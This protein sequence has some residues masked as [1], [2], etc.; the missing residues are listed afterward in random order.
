MDKEA[1]DFDKLVETRL[2]ASLRPHC[3]RVLG[4]N[5]QGEGS[6]M[7]KVLCVILGGGQGTR[8]FP[9]TKERCKPAMPLLG[10]YRLIDVAISNCLN[11][12]FKHIYI[13]T[14][15]LSESLNKHINRT[16]QMDSFS[17]GFIEIIAA[18][19]SMED[20]NWFQGTA[21]A[22]R[23]CLKHFNDPAVEHVLVLSGD[24]LYKMNLRE[25]YQYH[26]DKKA[27]VTLACNYTNPEEISG[28]G[29]M[30]IDDE[31]RINRFI[32]K[33]KNLSEVKGMAAGTKDAP[34]FLSSMGIYL[35]KKA[36]LIELLTK[37][38]KVDFGKE[39]I[40]DAIK[41]KSAFAF[42]FNG[43]WRDIGTIKNFYNENLS[44]TSSLPPLDLFDEN[45]QIFTRTRYLPPAK[46]EN[47]QI[48]RS[49]V[50][51]GAIVLSSKII[52]SVIGLRLRVASGSVIEDTIAMGSD[53]YE[54][55]D[56][57][58]K[59]A[60]LGIPALGIGKNCRIS[61]AILDKDVRIG[62]NAKIINRKN[63]ENFDGSDYFIRDGIVI[64]PKGGVIAAGTVV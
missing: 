29:I 23:R 18:E 22:V 28:L 57:M 16:Y 47:S 31:C 32:E 39:I 38:K 19:Q 64:V 51:E 17:K 13:L 6:I 7:K 48:E 1:R 56:E 61:R 3:R 5:K 42:C 49:V 34:V 52:H 43:Y 45:W 4:Q 30:G 50:A 12:G 63:L 20:T 33:P 59:N 40:P 58:N 14:Q 62:D 26:L 44:M 11:S 9:L 60:A 35:F 24:Q 27:D 10:K 46:F 54:T 55:V 8:L 2:I 25:M 41:T 53:Y 36:A 15:F 21:D 37:D